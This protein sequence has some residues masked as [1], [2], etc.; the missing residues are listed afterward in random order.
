LAL[1]R[2]DEA[3]ESKIQTT[4]I[5]TWLEFSIPLFH[6]GWPRSGQPNQRDASPQ[7]FL[8]QP[9]ESEELKI[10]D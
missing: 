8:T 6:H 5:Q 2:A 7:R 9:A 3:E 1:R 4:D 10:E